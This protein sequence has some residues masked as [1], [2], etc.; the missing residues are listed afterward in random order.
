[1]LRIMIPL[2][3]AGL[4][5]CAAGPERNWT[6]AGADG[7]V[8]AADLD[9]CRDYARAEV[10]TQSDIDQDI[11]ASSTDPYGPG[12]G[13]ATDFAAAGTDRRYRRVLDQCMLD[14]GY[15]VRR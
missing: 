10:K 4:S 6:K 12:M 3:A 8:V 2:L 13:G 11:A 15:G 14:L 7:S 5:A 1:M 9:A